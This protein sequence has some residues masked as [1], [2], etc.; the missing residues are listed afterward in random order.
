MYEQVKKMERFMEILNANRVMNLATSS[1][2]KPRSSIMEYVM[3]G[4]SMFFGTDPGSIKGNNLAKNPKLSL[5]VGGMPAYLALDGKATEAGKKDAEAYNKVLL[6]RHPEFKQF[7]ES[8][9]MKLKVFKVVID[10]V[11]LTEG[12]GPAKVIKVG[13]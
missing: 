5:T 7:I 8:G 3:I 12:H 2:D 10:T 9:M 1:N 11:Y 6:E 4:D 13:K